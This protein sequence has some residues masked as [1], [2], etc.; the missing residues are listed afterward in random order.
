MTVDDVAVA[1]KEGQTD[2]Y[3]ELWQKVERFVR[4]MAIKRYS[5]VQDVG[6]ID[7]DDL[8]Q[9][10]YLGLVRAV[11]TYKPDLCQFTTWL[12]NHLKTAFDDAC[13]CSS[14]RQKKDPIHRAASLD[15]PVYSDDPEG[16]TLGDSIPEP[17]DAV[18]A[19][20]DEV[21][22]E[23]LQGAIERLLSKL[24]PSAADVIRSSYIDGEPV[25]AIAKRYLT[26]TKKLYNRRL[27]YLY[28]LRALSRS[29]KEGRELRQYIED[30]TDYYFHVGSNTF[31]RT[32]SSAPEV[33][34]IKR[35]GIENYYLYRK[36]AMTTGG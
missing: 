35:E 27:D 31:Q 32:Q 16:P 21:F 14:I 3:A 12:T 22:Q 25:A 15:S 33:L 36:E 24:S 6:A 13:G 18:S 9:A 4:Y 19:I 1:I 8:I 11:E 30:S 26:T 5:R 34:A 20:D 29:T 2:L 23:Q 17:L 28:Q 10:G 7:L